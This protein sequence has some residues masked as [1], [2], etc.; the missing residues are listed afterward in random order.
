MNLELTEQQSLEAVKEMVF[1]S[2][3]DKRVIDYPVSRSGQSVGTYLDFK[4]GR[5][6]AHFET[7]KQKYSFKK[8]WEDLQSEYIY[9]AWVAI[10]RFKPIVD[11]SNK[12]EKDIWLE[13]LNRENNHEEN[14]LIKYIKST[15]GFKIYEFANPNAFRTTTTKNGK[16]VHYTLVMDMESLD[17]LL[18]D[19]YER[20]AQPLQLTDEN[21]L[22]D[23]T[24]Y[25]YYITFFQKWFNEK[26]EEILT[27]NQV[28]FLEN[29]KK[30]SKDHHLTAEEFEEVTGVRWANYSRWLRRIES[31]IVKAWKEENPAKQSRKQV[32]NNARIEYL[33][34]FMRIVDCEDN[35]DQQNL[36]LTN[37]LIKGMN[38]DVVEYDVF[39]ITNKTLRGNDL[40][41]FNRLVNN[42]N[43]NNVP[44]S[45]KSLYAITELV[46]SQLDKL[47][48]EQARKEAKPSAPK[49]RKP[50]NRHR[51]LITYDKDGNVIK[52]EY[53][54]E[55]D[56]IKHKNVFFILP[57]G[58]QTQQR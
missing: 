17:G 56:V 46:M 44:L 57:T 29:L 1:H 49:R 50:K 16:K 58:A 31:R 55:E 40:I 10:D 21:M 33:K 20:D 54:L 36:L 24:M 5:L 4:D 25:E 43:F 3:F 32:Y 42:D 2:Y 15:V 34:E 41:E 7:L 45:S 14:K 23:N 47:T 30:C 22:F 12:T 11:S 19:S 52:H 18:S 35:L 9:Q 38:V 13:I 27:E 48:E 6:N 28:E 8:G 53:I 39:N 51:E 37:H 26:K